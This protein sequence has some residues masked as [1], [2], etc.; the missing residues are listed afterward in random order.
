LLACGVGASSLAEESAQASWYARLSERAPASFVRVD[1]LI[2]DVIQDIRYFGDDN[3]VGRPIEGYEAPVALLTRE[4]ATALARVADAV[5]PMGLRLCI[6]D[7]YRPEPAVEDIL[8]WCADSEDTATQPAFYPGLRKTNLRNEGYIAGRSA[9]SR[10]SCL[11]LTLADADGVP[12]DMGGTFDWFGPLSKHGAKGLTNEQRANRKLLRTE[13][14]RQGFGAYQR[15]WWHYTLKNEPFPNQ[16]FAFPVQERVHVASISRYMT[17]QY[18]T[19]DR[20]N[21]PSEKNEALK[22]YPQRTK[23]ADRTVHSTY[24]AWYKVA[25][26][27]DGP[28]SGGYRKQ[29]IVRSDNASPIQKPE[30]RPNGACPI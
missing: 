21:I 29:G 26:H 5:R 13:M 8:S 10:G 14:E 12:L 20:I 1:L 6:Y 15:E 30:H 17:K 24:A 19:A 9:H 16:S 23:N 27:G 22:V 7:A 2:P 4:A 18:N 25:V 3:F 28:L 11:D